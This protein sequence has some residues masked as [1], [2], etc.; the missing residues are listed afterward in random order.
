METIQLI[1]RESGKAE[2]FGEMQFTDHIYT[3]RDDVASVPFKETTEMILFNT[4]AS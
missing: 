2:S 3:V 1:V 4:D